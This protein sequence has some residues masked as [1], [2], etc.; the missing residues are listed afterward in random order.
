V[1]QRIAFFPDVAEREAV[2]DVILPLTPFSGAARSSQDR[3]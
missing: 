1:L 2:T 3:A